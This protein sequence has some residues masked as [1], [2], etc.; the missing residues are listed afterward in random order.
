RREPEPDID[1]DI[2]E[3]VVGDDVMPDETNPVRCSSPRIGCRL[4]MSS[5]MSMNRSSGDF[6]RHRA[7][8]CSR[9]GG[10]TRSGADSTS[11]GGGRVRWDSITERL[12]GAENGYFPVS[13]RYIMIPN[14]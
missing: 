12:S 14:A 3:E 7:T 10:N 9:A 5:V 8:A 6:L 1:A 13:A 4:A 2:D 11:V